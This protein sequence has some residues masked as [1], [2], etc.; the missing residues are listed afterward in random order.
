MSNPFSRSVN[1][2]CS[3]SAKNK[4][5]ISMTVNVTGNFNNNNQTTGIVY[6]SH[7]GKDCM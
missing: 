3:N 1:K 2:V 4:H 6:V 5:K 7:F